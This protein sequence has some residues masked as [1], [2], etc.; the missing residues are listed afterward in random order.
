VFNNIAF[1]IDSKRVAWGF[2]LLDEYKSRETRIQ[3]WNLVTNTSLGGFALGRYGWRD[4]IEFCSEPKHILTYRS[5]IAIWDIEMGTNLDKDSEGAEAES[6]DWIIGGFP[7]TEYSIRLQYSSDGDTVYLTFPENNGVQTLQA[8]EGEMGRSGKLSFESTLLQG[9]P[10]HHWRFPCIISDEAFMHVDKIVDV[11]NINQIAVSNTIDFPSQ[12]TIFTT[13]FHISGT[14][15]A[16]V[17]TSNKLVTLR[18]VSI[19]IHIELASATS[20]TLTLFV[21]IGSRTNPFKRPSCV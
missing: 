15:A 19:P 14:L 18:L 11:S 20:G 10:D 2:N 7:I 12:Q 17:L 8:I 16:Y 3:L 9:R 5:S 21:L 6:M 4:R 1:D 13:S